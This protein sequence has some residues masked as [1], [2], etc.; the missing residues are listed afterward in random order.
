MEATVTVCVGLHKLSL[1]VWVA[2]LEYRVPEQLTM[3]YWHV[4]QKI[5]TCCCS[6]LRI[7]SQWWIA[8][9]DDSPWLD[10]Y[11]TCWYSGRI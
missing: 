10:V 2:H 1:C 7:Q 3:K 8:F 5:R 6:D 4:Q 9:G 11:R